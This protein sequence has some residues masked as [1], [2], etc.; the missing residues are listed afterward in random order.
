[1][2]HITIDTNRPEYAGEAKWPELSRVLRD[3]AAKFEQ[4]TQDKYKSS[5]I[6]MDWKGEHTGWLVED[7]GTVTTAA[8][9]EALGTT[10]AGTSNVTVS[11]EKDSL[12]LII[13][14]EGMGTWDGPYAP[15]LLE[16]HEGK[17]RLVIWADINQQDPTH[18]IDLSGALESTR[19]ADDSPVAISERT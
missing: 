19:A 10:S 17:V 4:Y 5:M 15:V 9:A 12:A 8:L 11:V 3:L 16:R 18:L 1:M 7:N 2:I 6:L 13:H 14:P